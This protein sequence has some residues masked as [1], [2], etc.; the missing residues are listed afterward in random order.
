MPLYTLLK[1]RINTRP[2]HTWLLSNT[3]LTANWSK[4][5]SIN[6]SLDGKEVMS[7]IGEPISIICTEHNR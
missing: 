5:S 2:Q 1:Q 3:N 7:K 6:Q 4:N